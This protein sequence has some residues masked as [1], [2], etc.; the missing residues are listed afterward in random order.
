MQYELQSVQQAVHKITQQSRHTQRNTPAKTAGQTRSRTST[1]VVQQYILQGT[2]KGN[3][4]LTADDAH[5]EL[6]QGEHTSRQ[7]VT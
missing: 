7:N 3:A 5:P 4:Q 6:G 2:H 1:A